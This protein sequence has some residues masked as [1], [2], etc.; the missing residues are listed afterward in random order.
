MK[1]NYPCKCGCAWDW[2]EEDLFT[3]GTTYCSLCSTC[4]KFTPDNLKYLEDQH[5]QSVKLKAMKKK[6]G[7]TIN[8]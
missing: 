6:Y 5:E 4:E 8:E 3:L 7:E 2:H 1:N